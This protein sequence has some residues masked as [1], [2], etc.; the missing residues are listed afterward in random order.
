MSLA[1]I[2]STGPFRG[3]VPYDEPNT[4]LFFGRTE[5]LAELYSLIVQDT[6]HVAVLCG[7]AGVGKTSLLRAGLVPY[8]VQHQ[9]AGIYLGAYDDVD[10]E[11]WQALGRAR[12]EPP[13]PGDSAA[14]YLARLARTS[15]GG[16]LL[17][18][19][20]VETLFGDEVEDTDDTAPLAHLSNWIASAVASSGNR[21][22]I[23]ICVDSGYFHRIGRLQKRA[24]LAPA[25]AT[26]ELARMGEEQVAQVLE[27]TVLNT[28]TF[29]EA[30]LSKAM[31]ADLCRTGPCL[32]ADLQ[33][34]AVATFDQR[35]TSLRRYERAGGATLLL[36]GFLQ[37][38]VTHSGGTQAARVLAACTKRRTFTQTE[39]AELAKVPISKVEKAVAAFVSHGLL[40]KIGPRSPDGYLLAHPCLESRIHAYTA[41][42]DAN[43][44]EARRLLRRRNLSNTSLNLIELLKVRKYLAGDLAA[45][46]LSAYRRGIRRLALQV[47]AAVTVLGILIFA[48][49]FELRSS[50]SLSFDPTKD[51]PMSRVVVRRG[52]ASLAFFNFIPAKPGFGTIIADTGFS[53]VQVATELSRRIVSGHASGTLD[54]NQATPIPAWLRTI[55]DGLGPVQRGISLV[56]LGDA[57]GVVSLK[58]AF[59]DPVLR[60]EALEALAVV[61]SGRAGEDEIL[62]SA[63]NDPSPDVRRRGVE[64]AA[65]IDRRLGKGTHATIL[66]TALADPSFAVRSTALHEGTSLD[67]DTAASILAVALADK[68]ISYRRLAEKGI[69]ELATR[70]PGAATNAVRH[71]LGSTDSQAR[72]TA[73]TLLEQI[74]ANAPKE[75]TSALHRIAS[76]ESASEEARVTVLAILRR[77]GEVQD[78]LRPM[79]EKAIGPESS[80]RLR[81]AALPIYAR[82]ID[83]AK[84]EE[85]A[86]SNSKGPPSLRATGAALWGVVAMKQPDTATR[87]LKAFLY[88][89]SPEV[90]V[91]AARAFGYLKRE[92]PEL[93]RRAILD[94]HIDVQRAAIESAVHLAVAQPALIAEDLGHALSKVRPAAR[95]AMVDA[96]GQIGQ[97]RP[98]A[99]L[100]PLARALKLGDA[101]TRTAAA[102]AFCEIAKIAPA[103]VAMYLRIAVK[104]NDRDVRTEAAACLGRLTTGDPK[105]AARMAAQLTLSDEMSVRIAAAN[106]LGALAGE[107]KEIVIPPL[108]NLVEDRE[109]TVRIAAVEALL[110][111]GKAKVPFGKQTAELEKKLSAYFVQ[112]DLEDRHLALRAGA[113]L[114]LVALVRQAGRDNDENMRL[115][116]IKTATTMSPVAIDILQTGAED[117][118]ALVR[119][120]AVRALA[121]VSDN[122]NAK[123]LPVFEVMLR[124]GDPA[125]RRAGALALGE[126]NGSPETTTALLTTVLHQRSVSVRTAAMQALSRIAQRAPKVATPLLES[127]LSDPAYD[128]R[129]TAIR[130]LGAVWAAEKTPSDILTI[131]V[132]SEADSV[133]RLVALEALV[134]K[135]SQPNDAGGKE[136][137]ALLEKVAESG[138]PLARLAAQV[139]RAFLGGHLEDMHAFLEK[140]YGG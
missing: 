111:C 21:L 67:P 101:P 51:S 23:L 15:P 9:V 98:A 77:S 26:Y 131:L 57:S 106:S 47:S 112:G 13:A 48:L 134:L 119:A 5:E 118:D 124:A 86:A 37:H 38:V 52:R 102:R 76:D 31:A 7:E 70:S 33:I 40:C 78:N 117:R 35:L 92:G 114:G 12:A 6:N 46:D 74:T 95:Q 139:G 84:V 89:T 22:R 85:L 60:R 56:L 103:A 61:G 64:V 49:I 109:R 44:Q 83:S 75:A 126:V 132:N 129:I 133:R 39:L 3:L 29:F 96:L 53:S 88:D 59:A 1:G 90:R 36:H 113:K 32:P 120:E 8:L 140:L 121:V 93:V 138:P 20:H 30:G 87:P 24:K 122:G 100:P 18:L 97:N 125:T 79:L 82:L 58:Q 130:G 45:E 42:S 91:E 17:I 116:A 25:L 108:I 115:E 80:P 137:R 41:A 14:E 99:V 68:E 62:S 11:I 127:A 107:A 4:P 50:Y 34:L 69:L 2:S 136:A 123:V 55:L 65:A 72:R 66:R 110:A 28:G 71:G 10:Q 43:T 135:A 94:P 128:V 54:K 63:L 105:G 81:T 16:T 104:D 27:Q 19:D 73:L